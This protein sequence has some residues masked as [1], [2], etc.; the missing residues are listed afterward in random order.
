M[1]RS[2]LRIAVPSPLYQ[3]F[4]YLVPANVDPSE[5]MA[6]VRVRVPFGR[7]RSIGV[8]LETAGS[9][10]IADG[11]LKTA[12][13]VLDQEPVVT[14]EILALARWASSYYHYPLGE[15]LAAVLPVALR[16]DRRRRPGRLNWAATESG[17]R[18]DIATLDRAPRQAAILN[19]L[20]QH[21]QGLDR[22]ALVALVGTPDSALAA[23]RK[24]GWA[25]RTEVHETDLAPAVLSQ[26]R[27]T[28]T[29]AQSEAVDQVSAA[30]DRFGVFLLD[31]VTG[32]GKTEVYLRLAESVLAKQRQVLIL[33]PEIGLTPQLVDRVR[34]RLDARLAVLHSGLSDGE[35]LD[36]WQMARS[37]EAAIVLGTRSAVFTPLARP[38]LLIVDEEHD[39]S[40]KQQEGFR[41]SARDLLVWRAR[42]LDIPVLLGSATPSLESL[43]NVQQGR[44]TEL[45]LPDRAGDARPPR[46]QLLDMRKERLEDGLSGPMLERIEQH[47]SKDG[48][49]MLFLNRRGYA[50]TLLCHECGWSAQCRRCDARMVMHQSRGQLRC[51]HCGAQRSLDARCGQCDSTDLRPI[52]QGTERVEQALARNFPGQP[53]VR[54]DRDNTRRKGSLEKMLQMARSGK[55]RL[56]LGT[57]MLAK[58]HHFP[59]VTLVGILDAD[60]GLY[61]TD[62]RASER[63]AQ[64]IVQVAGRAGRAQRA[65]EVCIQTHHPDHPLLRLLLTEGYSGFA[66]AAL[67]ERQAAQLPPHASLALLR[68][69]AVSREM[70]WSFL[71]QARDLAQADG[72]PGVELWGPVPAPMERRGGRYRAQL[73]LQAN[74]RKDLQRLLKNWVQRLGKLKGARKVRWSVDVD[75]GDTL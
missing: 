23:L 37:G 56:L 26:A 9:S 28:L 67:A 65:G 49:V 60:G 55:S 70:P 71:E 44:Y 5:L 33:V 4:D 7:T 69:E 2:I 36:A 32:S 75:P 48:Q 35:R 18:V 47:L 61:G 51:H 17:R 19:V 25:T 41:Y 58:G 30:L 72:A 16:T 46:I 8:L 14:P 63:M 27:Q 6:G 38:G 64:L 50:P 53:L 21:P 31:G 62:F 73:V 12:E 20:L 3:T 11:Q 29:Q 34:R 74:R 68:A 52:G 24:K 66:Q 1:E 40:L 54:I 22:E 42:H 13:A 15:V 39:A 10:P 59:D 45:R 43:Y 57:Q